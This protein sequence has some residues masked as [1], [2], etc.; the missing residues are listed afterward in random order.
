GRTAVPL[1]AGSTRITRSQLEDR[2]IDDW[3]DFA[4]RGDAAV[5]YSRGTDSVNVRGV[6][7]DRVVTRID[8]IRL[9]WLTDGARGEQG[10][11]S[12]VD[13]GSLSSVDLVRGA[14]AAAS[15]SLTGYLDLRTLEPDDLLGQGES[16]GTLLRSGY[17][18]ADD[19]WDARVALAGRLANDD[20]RWLIQ[21]GLRR[22][23]ELDNM[24]G[25]GGYGPSREQRNPE[26]T[27]QHN[28]MF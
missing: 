3:D 14:G 16:F 7:R 25:T 21:A 27:E 5:N 17:D 11:L 15:G 13:F 19:G 12:A 23:H 18:S 10:G 28:L 2:A 6:D 4:R 1:P 26:D 24:G 20:T 22:G 9:P 8:G